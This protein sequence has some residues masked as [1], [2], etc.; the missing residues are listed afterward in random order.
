MSWFRIDNTWHH[1]DGCDEMRLP[2]VDDFRMPT[3]E[4]KICSVCVSNPE[5]R[6]ALPLA[7]GGIALRDGIELAPLEGCPFCAVGDEPTEGEHELLHVPCGSDTLN[8]VAAVLVAAHL[9]KAWQRAASALAGQLSGQD[10]YGN[11]V[12]Q[13]CMRVVIDALY[14]VPSE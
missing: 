2:E 8:A 1:E 14:R 10:D 12:V 6:D 9:E 11:R 4:N 3:F 7:L 5:L 13:K